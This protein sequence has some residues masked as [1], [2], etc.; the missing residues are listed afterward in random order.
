M[1]KVWWCA[2]CG[3]KF[4]TATNL[5]QFIKGPVGNCIKSWNL[6][7]CL[8]AL[9][10]L[11]FLPTSISHFLLTEAAHG[12]KTCCLFFSSRCPLISTLFSSM[13]EKQHTA[14]IANEMHLVNAL[15]E[16][17]NDWTLKTHSWSDHEILNLNIKRG[18]HKR[19]R[20][21]YS[22]EMSSGICHVDRNGRKDNKA[23]SSLSAGCCISP[24]AG[25]MEKRQGDSSKPDETH[26][27]K[28][29]GK[30]LKTLCIYKRERD[31]TSWPGF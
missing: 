5:N 18:Q 3:S 1:S 21:N 10:V 8:V 9:G 16:F 17:P 24:S 30:S 25:W 13:C 12:T 2:V 29:R 15:M 6:W 14:N 4:V 26:G 7:P 28:I 19:K 11:T 22:T 20:G 23:A 31:E 27:V